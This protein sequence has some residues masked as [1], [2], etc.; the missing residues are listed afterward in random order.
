MPKSSMPTATMSTTT[1]S[2]SSSSSSMMMR[3]N[4]KKNTTTMTTTS[5]TRK[6]KT[7][8]K[9]VVK[10]A[11]LIEAMPLEKK[12]TTTMITE[13]EEEE[14]GEEEDTAPQ[15]LSQPT[16]IP[17]QKRSSSS[18]IHLP[19]TF[20]SKLTIHFQNAAHIHGRKGKLEIQFTDTNRI[21]ALATAMTTSTKKSPPK[22]H[23]QHDL[24]VPSS[25]V[26]Y[27]SQHVRITTDTHIAIDFI[28]GLLSYYCSFRIQIYLLV[29]IM[30]LSSQAN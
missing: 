23:Q 7:K 14:E 28:H 29:L 30:F 17:Y 2:S 27:H 20:Q 11:Y 3:A 19:T 22:T 13:E 9:Q 15:Q 10:E 24:L 1:T 4:S 5:K 21:V 18:I 6:Q 26:A 8:T 12:T 16:W 25:T